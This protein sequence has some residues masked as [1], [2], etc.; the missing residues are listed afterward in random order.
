MRLA[1]DQPLGSGS[2]VLPH[3][4]VALVRPARRPQRALVIA[5]RD[6]LRVERLANVAGIP[7]VHAATRRC[8]TI[9]STPLH[10]LPN[11]CTANGARAP[12]A[13]KHVLCNR[14]RR[15]RPEA[16]H[17]AEVAE[18][19]PLVEAF[20]G[21]VTHWRRA[22]EVVRSGELGGS[23]TEASTL[24]PAAAA[25]RHP[26]PLRAGR[27]RVDGHR[28]VRREHGVLPGGRRARGGVGERSSSRQST[29]PA[30]AQR[31][32][33]GRSGRITC[34]L[35]SLRLLSLDPREAA[36][37]RLVSAGAPLSPAHGGDAGGAASSNAWRADLPVSCAFGPARGSPRITTDPR[38]SPTCA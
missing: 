23:D 33:D 26:L 21:A 5:A 14:S 11:G 12:R 31:F 18:S 27:R 9:R 19:R 29:A 8:S 10:P 17:M 32:A 22:C 30:R 16:T 1:E 2:S 36:T 35:A 20:H 13:G 25:G 37:A 28:L 34:S 38:R 24:N 7:R 6:R 3:A 4:P 15:T